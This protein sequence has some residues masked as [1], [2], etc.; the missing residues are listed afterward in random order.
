MNEIESGKHIDEIATASNTSKRRIMQII[1]LAFV[2]PDIVKSIF[3]GKQP[4][5]L[6]TKYLQRH[7]L[8]ADWQEQRKIIQAL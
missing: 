4:C 2:A 6:T 3:Q 1:N 7:P 5:G 8:P